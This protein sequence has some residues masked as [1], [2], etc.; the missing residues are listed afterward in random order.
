[1]RIYCKY[2]EFLNLKSNLKSFHCSGSNS[3][4]NIRLGIRTR[5]NLYIFKEKKMY[6]YVSN[7]YA[8]VHQ[9]PPPPSYPVG[10][11]PFAIQSQ[12]GQK[13]SFVINL[14]QHFQRGFCSS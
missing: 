10:Q 7:M 11:Q 1:M 2:F 9:L 8:Y 13:E 12:N 4:S 5:N 3:S 14:G 6:T